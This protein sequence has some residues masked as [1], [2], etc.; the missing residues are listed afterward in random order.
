[1]IYL[2]TAIIFCAVLF[3]CW[4][5]SKIRKI[6]FAPAVL[7]CIILTPLIGYLVVSGRPL[8]N[9]K[10]CKWCGNTQNEAEFCGICGKNEEGNPRPDRS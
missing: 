10:G 3:F 1:M 4:H 6:G 9:P 8:R 5:E 7:I 2:F